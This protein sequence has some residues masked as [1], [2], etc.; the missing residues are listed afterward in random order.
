MEQRLTMITLGVDDIAAARDFFENGLGWQ[1]H[2]GS[3]DNVVFFETGASVLG[4]YGREALGEEAN[5]ELANDQIPPVSISWNGRTR[6][7]VDAAYAQALAAGAEDLS[8]PK[9]VFWGGYSGYVKILGRFLL[10]LAHN[11]FW[12]VHEDGRVQLDP[13]DEA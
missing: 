3:N 8:A 6:E 9:P 2:A 10:E 11:P 13:S 12:T 4:L 1:A 7:E 5:A